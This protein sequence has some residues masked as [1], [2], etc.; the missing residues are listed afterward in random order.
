MYAADFRDL[1]V[2]KPAR[3][4]ANKIFEITK[5]FP[6]EERYSLTI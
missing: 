1:E 3:K 4:L 2:D 5:K 6:S